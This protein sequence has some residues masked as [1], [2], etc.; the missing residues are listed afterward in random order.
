MT[1]RSIASAGG[2]SA[3]AGEAGRWPARP[4][5]QLALATIGFGVNFWA[6]AL[7]SPLG[8]A[9]G[10]ELQLT[11]FEVSLLVAI[12]V[13]VGSLG[14]V[15]VGSLTDRFGAPVMFPLVSALTIVPVLF[16]GL[17]ANSFLMLEVGGFVLGLGGTA[18]AVGVPH[19]N[20]WF[21]AARR[22]TALGV[23]GL[24]MGGTAISAFTTV[25]IRE[26][27]GDEAPFVIVAVVLAVY[28]IVSRLLLREPPGTPPSP[29]GGLW[30]RTWA[31]FRMPATL[32]LSWLYAVGFG[33]FVAFSV[34]LPTFLANAYDLTQNDAALR[35]AGFVVLAVLCRPVGGVLSDRFGGVQVSVVAFAV[36]TVFAALVA[37]QPP[38]M[39]LGTVAFLGMAAALGA[40]SGATFA[41]VAD[42]APASAV[43][44]VTGV[45]G[46]AGGLGGFI[47]PLI[48][49]AVYTAHGTYGV[50]FALLAATSL[51]T[52]LF[53]LGPV[54]KAAAG[55]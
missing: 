8:K 34:Y 43:G 9:Y 5:L 55:T 12:P 22:G 10:A 3:S 19:V 7:L 21:A 32:M 38:L 11:N 27:L 52:L 6:W 42:L 25:R 23:F 47:P 26:A 39:P 24:G 41:I 13:I 30:A 35:T 45:V 40:S 15:F 4:G 54:R 20:R 14:R 50:G 36:T 2:P 17:F 29:A 33:G 1:Q 49:G 48:M 51:L 28:A 44:A 31:T 46:A 16:V 37:F 53:T 18:F